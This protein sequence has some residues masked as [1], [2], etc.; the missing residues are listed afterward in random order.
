MQFLNVTSH[1]EISVIE[2]AINS[3]AML[4]QRL[5]RALRMDFI[6][7]NKFRI[8]KLARN[9]NDSMHCCFEWSKMRAHRTQTRGRF[10]NRCCS[11]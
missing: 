9:T 6:F 2:L 4:T 5:L 3:R 1:L 10:R 8:L 7:E 11:S